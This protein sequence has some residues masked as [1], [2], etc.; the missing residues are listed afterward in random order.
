MKDQ[1]EQLSLQRIFK[2]WWPLAASWL[3]MG[4]ESPVLSAVMAR[5]PDAEI[6]LAAYG[7]IVFPI[8]LLIEAP[9]IMLLSAST[10]LCVDWPSYR[11][12]HRFMLYS[13]VFLTIAYILT[14]FTP[15]YY[16]LTED[17]IG[18]PQEIIEPARIGF[19]IMTPWPLSIAFRRFQQGV[20]IRFNQSKAVGAGTMV[21]LIA[22]VVVL[23]IGYLIGSIPGVIVATSAQISGVIC[24]A[25]YAGIRVRPI[26]RENLKRAPIVEPPLTWG[27]FARFYIPLS[28]TS[29]ISLTWQPIGSAAMSRMS[30]PLPSLAVWPVVSGLIFI[31]RGVG[32]AYNETVVALLDRPR[33]FYGLR[34]F[35]GIMM[36]GISIIYIL[37]AA[38]P[39]A[40]VWFADLT[41]LSPALARMATTAFWLSLPVPALT[42]LQSWY[43]GAI[44]HGKKTRAIPE[45]MVM[46]LVTAVIILALGVYSEDWIGLYVGT[47]AFTFA[48][49]SQTSWLW[50]RS[51][52]IL[53]H[54]ASRDA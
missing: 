1:T 30:M 25:V 31:F 8:M 48:N 26:L 4:I 27:G 51:R 11:K 47:V 36:G 9:I 53:H 50:L 18:A 13:S 38:T 7:G 54:L 23:T 41:A 52:N 37:F 34:K 43:Q 19:M 29:F 22:D 5:L 15:F 6:N 28:L 49:I 45:A 24:E 42:A 2:T 20:M 3:L 39:I 12:V 35:S 17:V 14:A 32:M 21:R 10:A 46:F 44:V 16:F 33:S 40:Y